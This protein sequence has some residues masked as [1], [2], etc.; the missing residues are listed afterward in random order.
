M[1]KKSEWKGPTGV[2]PRGRMYLKLPDDKW[3]QAQNIVAEKTGQGPPPEFRAALDRALQTWQGVT[4]LQQV[5]SPKAARDNLK[6]TLKAALGANDRLNDLDGYSRSIL[7]EIIPEGILQLYEMQSTIIGTLSQA[8]KKANELPTTRAGVEDFA[9]LNMGSH[10][11]HSMKQ[12]LD[13]RAT[14]TVSG[15][16]AQLYAVL[17]ETLETLPGGKARV[18]SDKKVIR[19]AIKFFREHGEV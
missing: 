13:Q 4:Y 17:A 9:A 15:L 18:S 16:F 7:S 3:E 12:H 1:T 14:S 6:R 5:G 19:R 11:A 10:L 8:V 2:V